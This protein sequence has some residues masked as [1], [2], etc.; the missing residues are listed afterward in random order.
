MTRSIRTSTNS[1]HTGQSFPNPLPQPIPPL[2]L[3][4]PHHPHTFSRSLPRIFCFRPLV[5]SD[6]RCPP[7]ASYVASLRPTSYA[8]TRRS[9]TSLFRC[10]S[11]PSENKL[12]TGGK[13]SMPGY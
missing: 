3:Y 10:T 11:G 13:L 6:S 2:T 7:V 1:S 12:R 9:A 5:S 8:G 4:V